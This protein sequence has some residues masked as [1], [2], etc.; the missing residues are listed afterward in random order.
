[1]CLMGECC[2]V[3]GHWLDHSVLSKSKDLFE[4]SSRVR[5]VG[6]LRP[7]CGGGDKQAE[8]APAIKAKNDQNTPEQRENQALVLQKAGSADP[9]AKFK[10]L[11]WLISTFS[12]LSEEHTLCGGGDKQAATA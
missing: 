2:V 4:V 7:L 8:L 6:N 12:Q 1:M 9:E 3:S 5:W 11:K 10:A